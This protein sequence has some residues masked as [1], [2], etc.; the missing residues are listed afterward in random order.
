MS[1]HVS[2]INIPPCQTVVGDK[3]S[4]QPI[5]GNEDVTVRVKCDVKQN[6][7]NQSKTMYYM[8]LMLINHDNI[9]IR[10]QLSKDNYNFQGTIRNGLKLAGLF[11]S[12]F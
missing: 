1:Q 9:D 10:L 2:T 3:H 8:S 7:I 12:S 11:K 5:S 6:A 4:P